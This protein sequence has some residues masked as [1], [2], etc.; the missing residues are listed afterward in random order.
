MYLVLF[1]ANLLCSKKLLLNFEEALPLLIIS[2]TWS[3]TFP[4]GFTFLYG[5]ELFLSVKCQAAKRIVSFSLSCLSVGKIRSNAPKLRKHVKSKNA[6][7]H[8]EYFEKFLVG[9]Q[10]GLKT[11]YILFLEPTL[12]TFLKFSAIVHFMFAKVP[13]KPQKLYGPFSWMDFRCLKATELLQE[14]SLLFTTKS[15]VYLA[16]ISSTSEE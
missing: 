4:N 15:S 12:Q 5:L 13:T 14:D 8:S 2:A 7:G 3:V 16:L 6:N 9:P 10:I 11:S 1:L